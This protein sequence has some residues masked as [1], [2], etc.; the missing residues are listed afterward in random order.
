MTRRRKVRSRKQLAEL[1]VR[2][3]PWPKHVNITLDQTVDIVGESNYI[4]I[5]RATT[6][7]Q[8]E[9]QVVACLILEPDNPYDPNAIAVH[10][11]AGVVGYIAKEMT[12]EFWSTVGALIT[13]VGH[14]SVALDLY[15]CKYP[16]GKLAMNVDPNFIESEDHPPPPGPQPNPPPPATPPPTTLPP[17][18]PTTLPPPPAVPR[19][20]LPPPPAAPQPDPPAHG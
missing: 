8:D 13:T 5:I 20:D 4:D 14:C 11:E 2:P 7:G 19:P 18:P 1:C 15:D 9:R 12:G 10:A 16:Y 17:P 3:D 6:A